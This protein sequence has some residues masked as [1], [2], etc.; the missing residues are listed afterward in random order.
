M[1]LS[2]VDDYPITG[3]MSSDLFFIFI[4]FRFCVCFFIRILKKMKGLRLFY[5][6]FLIVLFYV[7]VGTFLARLVPPPP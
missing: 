5:F 7:V 3:V 1:V 6:L 2:L 4:F